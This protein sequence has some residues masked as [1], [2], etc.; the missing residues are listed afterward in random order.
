MKSSEKGT[1][2]DSGRV[3]ERAPGA[4]MSR[5]ALLTKQEPLLQALPSSSTN[6][7]MDERLAAAN[8][9]EGYSASALALARTVQ[10]VRIAPRALLQG[11]SYNPLPTAATEEEKEEEVGEEEEERHSTDSEDDEDTQDTQEEVLFMR[12]WHS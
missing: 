2:V 3:I 7:D 9:T 11:L 1:K 10:D 8:T 5:A 6:S 12:L 4:P